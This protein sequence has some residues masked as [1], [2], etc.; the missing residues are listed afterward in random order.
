[1]KDVTIVAIDFLH[2]DLTRYAIERSLDNIDAKEVLIVSDKEIL[3]GARHIIRDPAIG[4]AECANIM[5]KGIAAY[6]KTN[7]ALYVQ[8]DGVANDYSRWTDDFLN[9]DYIGAPWPW[10]PEGLNI[11]NGGFS[12]RSQRLL[13]ACLD[14]AISLTN[15]EP[16]AEDNIIGINKRVYLE[17]KYNVNFAP[18]TVARQFSFELGEYTPSFGFHGLWNVF[19]LMTDTDIDYF[20]PRLNYQ[21][22]NVYKWC[23][24]LYSVVHRGRTDV[25]KTMVEQLSTHNPELLPAVAQYLEQS[26]FDDTKLVL[27]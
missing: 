22:W 5:L 23:H 19:N 8:W 16:L 17:D 4:I 13:N 1:M 3:P 26:N 18:T 12:L 27:L 14:P 9:Y 6:I 24:V 10:Q 21:G 7:H 15:E 2:H 25:Y 11:G 20:M